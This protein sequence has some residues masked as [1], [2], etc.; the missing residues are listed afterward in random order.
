[1]TAATPA[2]GLLYGRKW[3]V[4]RFDQMVYLIRTVG[5]E[6]PA[7]LGCDGWVPIPPDGG[8]VDVETF[9]TREMAEMHA[10]GRESPAGKILILAMKSTGATQDQLLADIESLNSN[11]DGWQGCVGRDVAAIWPELSTGERLVAALFASYA[12][13]Y[14]ETNVKG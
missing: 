1:M 6:D 2:A 11:S 4:S 8:D 5:A 10:R 3:R 12:Q 14:Y 7:I 9:V 13:R